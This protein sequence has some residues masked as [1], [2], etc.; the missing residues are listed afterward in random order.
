MALPIAAV[1]VEASLVRLVRISGSIVESILLLLIIQPID[2]FPVN[3]VLANK[4]QSAIV[5]YSSRHRLPDYAGAR[6]GP[7][8]RIGSGMEKSP[9]GSRPFEKRMRKLR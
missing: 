1:L 3:R 5:H 7:V 2:H 4:T 9:P 6:S 8:S